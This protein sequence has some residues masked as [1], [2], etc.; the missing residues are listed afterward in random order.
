MRVSVLIAAYNAESHVAEAVDS[1]LNQCRPPDEVIV[2]DDG[3]T[4]RTGSVLKGFGSRIILQSQLNRGQAAALN[5]ATARATG[6]LLGFCDADDLWLPGKLELQIARMEESEEIEA[7]F[8]FVRQFISPDVPQEKRETLRPTME[9]LHG[10]LKQCML[11]RRPAFDRIGPFEESLPATFFIEWLGRAKMQGL[12][13]ASLEEIIVLRRL[14][15]ANG[16]RSNM[17]SQDHETLAALRQVIA[18]RRIQP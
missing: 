13:S 17:R 2:V 8:G 9:V 10:E 3:S 5:G 4:D 12:R 7:I 1:V 18:R 15:L 14:H 6:D 11:I 16:G